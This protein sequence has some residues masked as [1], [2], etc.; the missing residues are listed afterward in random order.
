M[1]TMRVTPYLPENDSEEVRC[2]IGGCTDW[3][4]WIV[5]YNNNNTSFDLCSLHLMIKIQELREEDQQMGGSW[6]E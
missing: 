3:S 4:M 6:Q 5:G 2:D 1:S